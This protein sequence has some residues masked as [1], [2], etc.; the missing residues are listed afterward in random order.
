MA[1]Q[2]DPTLT[3]PSLSALLARGDSEATDGPNTL[4][5][6]GGPE[7]LRMERGAFAKLDR[8]GKI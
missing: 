6:E 1:T 3:V 8:A 7:V 2:L 4:A 5:G